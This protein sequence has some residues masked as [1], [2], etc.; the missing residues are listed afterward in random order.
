[1]LDVQQTVNI[2]TGLGRRVHFASDFEYKTDRAVRNALDMCKL[3]LF[4]I[5]VR[6]RN[7]GLEISTHI[8]GHI[9]ANN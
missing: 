4:E 8:V 2:V 7:L 5:S 1:M 9:Q 6:L 3:Y